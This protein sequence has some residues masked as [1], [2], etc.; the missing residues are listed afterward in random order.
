MS[1]AKT[2]DKPPS[3]PKEAAPEFLRIAAAQI[4]AKTILVI[5][6]AE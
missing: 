1:E 4:G 5:G 2:S 3:Q 6:P